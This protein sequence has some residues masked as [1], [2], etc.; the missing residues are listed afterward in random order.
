MAR[1]DQQQSGEGIEGL[2]LAKTSI[3]SAY[4]PVPIDGIG[5]H[6]LGVDLYLSH[7]HKDPVLYRAKGS[8]YSNADFV[9]LREQGITHFYIPNVQ[10]RQFQEMLRSRIGEAIGDDKVCRNERV[11]IVRDSCGK[12]IEDFTSNASLPGLSDT[13]SEIAGQFSQWCENESTEF[14]YLYEMS[15]HDFYTT[16]H[17]VNVGVGCTL[18]ASEL[19]G[20]GHPQVQ[21]ITLGGLIHDVGK[22]G[23]DTEIL[24][25]EGKLSDEEWDQIRNHPRV[26]YEVLCQQQGMDPLA[27]DM[28]LNHHERLDGKGYPNGITGDEISLPARICCVVDIYDALSSARPYRG[29]IPPCKV[30]E[31]MSEDVGTAIDS[32]VFEAWKRVL[33][34]MLEADPDR[35]VPDKPGLKVPA[36]RS[37]LPS[38][39][40]QER[41]ESGCV[42]LQRSNGELLE[43]TIDPLRAPGDIC[44]V[45]DTKFAAGEQVQLCFE[46]G[47][48]EQVGYSGI[49]YNAKGQLLAVFK[50]G[51]FSL[52]AA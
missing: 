44:L 18:L 24:N 43:L 49:R 35:A 20:A 25:K 28:T 26:G 41:P 19:L 13:I 32:T 36:M 37:M 8:S 12:L 46:D 40:C 39:L 50:L 4:F 33:V 30:L 31:M 52:H 48:K 21:R 5:E 15:E 10:H 1:I 17:M 22:R 11:R 38:Q 16:T 27:I 42:K 6:E 47:I 29:P 7:E 23:V 3:G 45:C 9:N 2:G 14:E 51:K 34:R